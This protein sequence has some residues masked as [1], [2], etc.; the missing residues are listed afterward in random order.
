MR[1]SLYRM[2]C[3]SF[4]LL[5]L[6]G[7]VTF[8]PRAPEDTPERAQVQGFTRLAEV[9][10]VPGNTQPDESGNLLIR[11]GEQALRARVALIQA[12]DISIDVQYFLW[13]NDQTGRYLIKQ[14]V[15]A[16][17]R[18]VEVRLLLDGWITQDLNSL[19]AWVDEQ[20][21]IDVRFYNPFLAETNVG[22][23]LNLA[24]D[25]DR[26]NRRMHNK[27]FTVDGIA[28]ITGGR[29][30]SD[31][32]FFH[33][34]D[35]NYLDA[36][37]LSIGPVVNQV[38]ESFNEYWHNRM[39]VPAAELSYSN[40]DDEERT[41]IANQ[42]A[43]DP[44]EPNNHPESAEAFL[45]DVHAQMVWAPTRF[46]ADKAGV[47][48]PSVGNL[49][50]TAA[51]EMAELVRQTEREMLIESA[52]LVL[53]PEVTEY[54]SDKQRSG[55]RVRFLTNSMA[56][57]TV[58]LNHASYAK[59]RENIVAS[60]IELYE[61]KPMINTCQLGYISA[62]HCRQSQRISLHT[63]TAVFDER[64]VYA[65]SFNFNLRSAYLNTE[66]ALIID[67]VEM[68][69]QLK[70]QMR[71]LMTLKASW[72]PKFLGDE[73]LWMTIDDNELIETRE[74]PN[75]TALE[76]FGAE[77]LSRVPGAEYY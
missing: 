73:L 50:K 13:K 60:G 40:I 21:N 58:F 30:I 32:Y 57:N 3:L 20:P 4:G 12:A 27:S 17:E 66:S 72:Q 19:L 74:E 65:G 18:G 15:E 47:R 54:L 63:K 37:V 48:D 1:K 8:Q 55:V 34:P 45:K 29:N 41:A 10:P 36:D 28:T 62:G 6:S 35:V 77:I 16:A 5:I 70:Q 26:L 67:S 69:A 22:R 42:L 75:T 9:L 14:L 39:T 64:F 11:N 59:Y 61:V 76:R 23:A 53:S 43:G 2:A 44:F 56:S 68:A 24:T 31:S 38:S 51:Q 25:F 71:N 33:H 49:P 46:V 7:C 52:Y